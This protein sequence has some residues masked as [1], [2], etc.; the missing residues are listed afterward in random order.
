MMAHWGA[1]RCRVPVFAL[2]VCVVISARGL[3]APSLT[4]GAKPVKDTYVLAEPIAVRVTFSNASGAELQLFLDYPYSIRVTF[5]CRDVDAE[6]RNGPV[7]RS[8]LVPYVMLGAH[9]D[10]VLTVALKRYLRFKKPKVYHIE[11]Y[12]GAGTAASGE[13]APASR[14]DILIRPGDMESDEIEHLTEGLTSAD[15]QRRLEA[16][17]LLCWVDDARV[18]PALVRA[19]EEAPLAGSEVLRALGKFSSTRSG[20]AALFDAAQRAHYDALR[21]LVSVCEEQHIAIPLDFYRRGLASDDRGRRWTL[22]LLLCQRGSAEHLPLVKS[23]THDDEV[24]FA[25]LARK[26]IAQIE[27]R[28]AEPSVAPGDRSDLPK[29]KPQQR[30]ARQDGSRWVLLLVLVVVS[31][32]VVPLGLWLW[33][34]AR[35]RSSQ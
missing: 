2:G 14:F 34:L 11:C 22:L 17:E 16:V 12:Q 25:E 28:A 6:S 10:H 3:G 4:V 21:T 13:Q 5:R 24:A 8:G 26:A 31:V 33:R 30:S 7:L 23:L 15:R 19:A 35:R 32:A 9:K 20:R 29:T 18:I 27:A 1:P